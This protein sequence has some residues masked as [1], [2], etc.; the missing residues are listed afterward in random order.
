MQKLNIHAAV[1]L[2]RYYL[3][4]DLLTSFHKVV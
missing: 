3:M 4:A 1:Q 2:P